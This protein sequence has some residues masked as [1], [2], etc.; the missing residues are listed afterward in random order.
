[1][2][3]YKYEQRIKFLV[4]CDGG[5]VIGRFETYADAQAYCDYMQEHSYGDFTVVPA[6]VM[7]IDATLFEQ[8][9]EDDTMEWDFDEDLER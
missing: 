8:S 5:N 7:D 9:R 2:S 3:N 4:L 1:M 6:N